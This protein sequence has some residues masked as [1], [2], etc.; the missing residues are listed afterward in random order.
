MTFGETLI[1]VWRQTLADGQEEVNLG[2]DSYPVTV[3][4]AKK[5]R[6]VEFSYG[7]RVGF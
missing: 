6:S 7:E 5:I 2:Q 3:F 4:R 1:M